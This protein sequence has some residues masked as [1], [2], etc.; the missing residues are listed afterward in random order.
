MPKEVSRRRILAGAAALGGAAALAPARA[1]GAAAPTSASTYAAPEFPGA[2]IKPGDL[3][4]QDLVTS[5]NGRF[6]GAPDYVRLVGS[7]DQACDALAQAVSAGKR[8]AP[9]SGGHCLEGFVTD[10]AVKVQLDLSPL[11]DIYYDRARRAIAVEPGALLRDVYKTLFTEWGVTIPA[12]LCPD[13]GAGGHFCGGGYGILARR[14]GVVPDHMY[15]VEVITVD[16]SGTPQRVVATRDA[17]DPNR[18]LFW[19][20][21]GGGGGN[22]GVVTKYWLRTPGATGTDPATLLPAPPRRAREVIFSWPWANLT[23]QSFTAIVKGYSTWH[24]ANSGPTSPNLRLYA[25]L[26]CL[27]KNSSPAISMTVVVDPTEPD[28]D[29][30]LSDFKAAVVTPVGVTATVTE[31]TFPWL[32]FTNALSSP[33]AGATVGLRTKSKGSYLRKSYTDAQIA[34]MWHYLAETS[35]VSPLAGV[36]LSGYGGKVNTVAPAATAVAQRD[37]V[38]KLIHTVYWSDPSQDSTYLGWNRQFYHDLYATTGGVPTLDGITDGSY[39]NYADVDL[40]DPAVN[41]SGVPWYRLYYKNN[42]ERLQQV[43]ARWDPLDIFQ[44]PLGVRPP[45]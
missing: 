11:K 38:L 42:Y 10:P 40:A 12:G 41:T 33:D 17:N 5:W 28:S 16:S 20:H 22:F 43:K 35:L 24:E 3:R 37:S 34:T 31:K 7:A 27:H 21:T 44:H 2:T 6:V 15:G 13:V 14:Q 19:A 4:Y 25:Q 23:Q 8:I 18:E 39:I 1:A 30:L 45:S 32:Q 26:S 36:L 9:R 29:Q